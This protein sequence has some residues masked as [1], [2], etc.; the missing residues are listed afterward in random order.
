MIEIVNISAGRGL[1]REIDLEEFAKDV[2]LPVS[3]YDE[4]NNW[5]LLRFNEDGSLIILLSNCEVYS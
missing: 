1:N 2:D 3:D 5:L 4:H